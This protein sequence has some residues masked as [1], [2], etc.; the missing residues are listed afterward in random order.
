[1]AEATESYDGYNMLLHLLRHHDQAAESP[2]ELFFHPSMLPRSYDK[3]NS[4]LA[5]MWFDSCLDETTELPG[6]TLGSSQAQD[7]QLVCQKPEAMGRPYTV[8]ELLSLRKSLPFVICNVGKLK[9]ITSGMSSP[10]TLCT[11]C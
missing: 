10:R 1:M 8:D 4:T 2:T 7:T 9:D 5:D 3:M 6:P 11:L